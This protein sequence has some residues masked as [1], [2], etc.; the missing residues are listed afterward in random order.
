MFK[1][2]QLEDSPASRIFSGHLN[3]TRCDDRSPFCQGQH[4][5]ASHPPSLFWDFDGTA[6]REAVHGEGPW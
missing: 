4:R 3:V 1:T 5:H 2:L 6:S